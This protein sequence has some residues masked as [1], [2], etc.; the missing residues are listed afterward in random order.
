MLAMLLCLM[1]V[2]VYPIQSWPGG[3]PIHSWLGGNPPTFQTWLGGGTPSSPGWGMPHLVLARRV[4]HPVLAGRDTPG[5]CPCPDLGWGTPL[6]R[7]GMEYP[8]PPVE[9]WTD[10]QSKNITVPHPSDAGGNNKLKLA[11]LTPAGETLTFFAGKF[12]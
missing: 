12:S 3:Y 2:G 1:G 8:P 9:V 5:Y 10:T 6:S 11:S 4:P 7:S